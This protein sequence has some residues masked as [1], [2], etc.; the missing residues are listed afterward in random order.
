MR[1]YNDGLIYDEKSRH[2]EAIEYFNLAVKCGYKNID[3][4][5]RRGSC[6][7]LLYQHEPAIRDFNKVITQRPNDCYPLFLSSISKYKIGDIDS[8]IMDV[9]KA[10]ILSLAENETNDE[11]REVALNL[12]WGT[13]TALYEAY[14]NNFRKNMN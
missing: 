9:Q 6:L 14:L 1:A 5:L 7:Q 4:F 12:G 10:I 3:V 11:Y 2:K 13:H 8:A